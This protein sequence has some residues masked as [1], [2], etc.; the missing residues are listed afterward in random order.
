MIR[1][2]RNKLVVF[3]DDAFRVKYR[4]VDYDLKN[5]TAVITKANSEG[6]IRMSV[7][8]TDICYEDQ[9]DSNV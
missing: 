2:I 9:G 5:E 4:I 8:W 7:K 1:G 3:T 6:K